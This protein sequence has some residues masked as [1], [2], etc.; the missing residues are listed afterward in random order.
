MVF[1]WRDRERREQRKRITESDFSKGIYP[2]TNLK[3]QISFAYGI[4]RYT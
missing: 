2:L 1:S 4:Y 3:N